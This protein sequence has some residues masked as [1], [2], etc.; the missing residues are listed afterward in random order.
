VANYERA[1]DAKGALLLLSAVAFVSEGAAL[2]AVFAKGARL[3]GRHKKT[4]ERRRCGTILAPY[5]ES[6]AT[7]L[8][9]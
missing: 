2:F 4:P 3:Q 1:V 8:K 6:L 9:L 7:T 5:N